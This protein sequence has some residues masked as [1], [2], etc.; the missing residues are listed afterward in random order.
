MKLYF[1]SKVFSA[2]VRAFTLVELI[3]AVSIM[4]TLL[5]ITLSNRPDAITRL[6]LADQVASTD[7]ML[8]QAQ[9]QGSSINS[10]GGTYGGAGVYFDLATATKVILFKDVTED[11][12]PSAIG[13][14]NGLYE[15]SSLESYEMLTLTRGNKIAKLCVSL[16]TSTPL[17]NTDNTP[18]VTNLTVSFNR[19]STQANIYINNATDTKYALG[20]VEFNGYK[21]P[22]DG[23]VR[24]LFIYRSGMMERRM[25]P[26]V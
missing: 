15:Q 3:V 21:A 4:I 2:H 26:C 11:S 5:T 20:C 17:C 24:S 14:G 9:L 22:M 7:L 1:S 12:I 18:P 10:L 16:S 23:Y 25:T 13:V 19:P 6:T 8:R